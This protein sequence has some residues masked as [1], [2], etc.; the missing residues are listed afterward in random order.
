MQIVQIHSLDTKEALYYRDEI[1]VR[2]GL[3]PLDEE[4]DSIAFSQVRAIKA[5][6]RIAKALR[7]TNALFEKE[8]HGTVYFGLIDNLDID[9]FMVPHKNRSECFIGLHLGLLLRPFG[10][11]TAALAQ[12]PDL[13][14]YVKNDVYLRIDRESGGAIRNSIL[15]PRTKKVI[16]KS[17]RGIVESKLLGEYSFRFAYDVT[18]A[19][20][21]FCFLHEFSHFARN[22]MEFLRSQNA[23]G[24]D[25]AIT[26]KL[27]LESYAQENRS[28]RD[29][30]KRRAI[31][32]DA[33]E[34]A[35]LLLFRCIDIVTGVATGRIDTGLASTKNI[36]LDTLFGETFAFGLFWLLMDTDHDVAIE[37][38]V[39]PPC[40]F[41]YRVLTYLLQLHAHEV[42]EIPEQDC[43]D[44]IINGMLEVENLAIAMG[45]KS[46][47][48]LGQEVGHRNAAADSILGSMRHEIKEYSKFKDDIER[49][50]KFSAL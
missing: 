18:T 30:L 22:H 9:A 17:F 6:K 29:S 20:V 34:Q 41:R 35:I 8:S 21:S 32:Y 28:G 19:I 4:F 31:E 48:W 25:G 39:H 14:N 26:E 45:R 23:D 10:V 11:L 50:S 46:L 38:S 7:N 13:L 12:Y 36:A 27:S 44:E 49:L 24:N 37:D 2:G 43:A 15:R 5:I 3:I 42:W 33:D 16:H 47:R 1:A 40:Y